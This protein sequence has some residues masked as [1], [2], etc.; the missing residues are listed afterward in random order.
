[1]MEREYL[2]WKAWNMYSDSYV[3]VQKGR[4][5]SALSMSF[6]SST[7]FLYFRLRYREITRTLNALIGSKLSEFVE[8][9]RVAQLQIFANH[10]QVQLMKTSPKI[11]NFQVFSKYFVHCFYLFPCDRGA[12]FPMPLSFSNFFYWPLFLSLG[13]L[14]SFTFG[15]F[16]LNFN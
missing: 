4:S 7:L 15:H 13:A 9:S 16:L 12:H 6:Y 8:N 2:L 14:F 5:Q 10:F 3:T 11:S 1:M